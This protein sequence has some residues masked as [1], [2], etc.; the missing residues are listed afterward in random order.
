[1]ILQYDLLTIRKVA[2]R[3][4]QHGLA[5]DVAVL[6]TPVKCLTALS[7]FGLFELQL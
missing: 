4:Q 1:M 2:L 6:S 5:L 3:Q 7:K